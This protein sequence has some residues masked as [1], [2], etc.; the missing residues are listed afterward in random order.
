MVSKKIAKKWDSST[1]GKSKSS[2]ASG[3]YW[4]VGSNNIIRWKLQDGI[5]G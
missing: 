1:V 5:L 2:A 3:A 4:L